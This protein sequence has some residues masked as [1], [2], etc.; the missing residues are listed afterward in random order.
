M[1]LEA[2]NEE[3]GGRRQEQAHAGISL[4]TAWSR[5]CPSKTFTA[6]NIHSSSQNSGSG[7]TSRPNRS[8]RD[9]QGAAALGMKVH[10]SADRNHLTVL[11]GRFCRVVPI[12]GSTKSLFSGSWHPAN[13]LL[14]RHRP[15]KAP[16]HRGPFSKPPAVLD[17]KVS[18]DAETL[19]VTFQKVIL[20]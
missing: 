16:S 1:P 17:A 14:V 15:T 12:L 6:S 11:K 13:L 4:H 18:V 10:T 2:T 19:Q 3:R 7:L 20:T 9:A 8:P 5:A